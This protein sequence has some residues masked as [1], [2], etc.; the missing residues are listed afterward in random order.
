MIKQHQHWPIGKKNAVPKFLHKLTACHSKRR[1]PTDKTCAPAK[2]LSLYSYVNCKEFAKE[3]IQDI[4]PLRTTKGMLVQTFTL[5]HATSQLK[6]SLEK[7]A[8]F[9]HGPILLLSFRMTR[10]AY[11]Y[12][13]VYILSAWIHVVRNWQTS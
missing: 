8:W 9:W 12:F 11:P 7:E 5:H 13:L 4:T 3:Q 2:A 6:M 10:Q 1:K